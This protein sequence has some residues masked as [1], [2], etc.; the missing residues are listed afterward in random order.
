M[1]HL[2]KRQHL[3]ALLI[4]LPSIPFSL[5]LS[6]L[7]LVTRWLNVGAEATYYWVGRPFLEVRRRWLI[8]C[9]RVNSA[10]KTEVA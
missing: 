1:T 7:V 5:P 6:I 2:T 10:V 8:H 9:E 4:M 3:V